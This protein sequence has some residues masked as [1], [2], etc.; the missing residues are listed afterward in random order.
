MDLRT[1]FRQSNGRTQEDMAAELGV[2]KQTVNKWL[3]DLG[4][5]ARTIY[6]EIDQVT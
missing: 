4:F 1:Y 3:A 2:S 6:V 5:E